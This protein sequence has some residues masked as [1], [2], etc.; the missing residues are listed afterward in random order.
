MLP[1]SGT[2][3]V[4]LVLAAAWLAA[5]VLLL[6]DIGQLPLRVVNRGRVRPVDGSAITPLYWRTWGVIL[7]AAAVGIAWFGL[8]N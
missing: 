6:F 5:G 1:V 7:I 8:Q 4:S 2:A 3:I